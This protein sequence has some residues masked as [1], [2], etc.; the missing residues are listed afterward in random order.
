LHDQDFGVDGDREP[1]RMSVV[2][3]ALVPA[4]GDDADIGQGGLIT[5]AGLRAAGARPSVQLALTRLRGGPTTAAYQR[6]DRSYTQELAT[7]YIPARVVNL[8]RV[9]GVP[10]LGAAVAGF[11]GIF[12]LVY[13]LVAGVRAR[14]RELAVLRALGLTSRRLRR[15][16]AWQGGLLAAGMVV[17]GMPVGLLVG[18]AAW[19]RVADGLGIAPDITVSPWVLLVGPLVLAVAVASSVVPARRARRESVATLLR[20]E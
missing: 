5:L 17:I 13:A 4:M 1:R 14:T 11:L 12:V 16:L 15:V 20:V 3:E 9:R 6:L 18:A 7:D 8:H 10:L 2:G 19:S